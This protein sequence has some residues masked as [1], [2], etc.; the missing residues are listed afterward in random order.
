[1]KRWRRDEKTGDTVLEKFLENYKLTKEEGA[2]ALNTNPRGLDNIIKDINEADESFIEKFCHL[3]GYNYYDIFEIDSIKITEAFDKVNQFQKSF[4]AKKP[5]LDY[6]IFSIIHKPVISLLGDIFADKASCF[7]DTIPQI[8]F[9][10]NSH[11]PVY[12][13]SDKDA[14]GLNDERNPLVIT[15]KD[16]N[17]FEPVLAF[18]PE[19]IRSCTV[20]EYDNKT[21]YPANSVIILKSSFS[22]LKNCILLF[23][24][25]I[26][27]DDDS[28]KI[29]NDS[30]SI[31]VNYILYSD[32][33]V[34][35]DAITRLLTISETP[36]VQYLLDNL[37]CHKELLFV[38]TKKD[39]KTELANDDGY[40]NKQKD[41][42]KKEE[43]TEKAY[44][45]YDKAYSFKPI[46]SAQKDSIQ[47]KIFFY[48]YND[49]GKF[50]YKLNELSVSRAKSVINNIDSINDNCD[51]VQSCE[52]IPESK[53]LDS[54]LKEEV[55]KGLKVSFG[56]ASEV[57][58]IEKIL[59]K[60]KIKLGKIGLRSFI[61]FL[62]IYS[63][64]ILKSKLQLVLSD[65]LLTKILPECNL[66]LGNLI[67]PMI[68]ERKNFSKGTSETWAKI[69]SKKIKNTI[70][71]EYFKSFIFIIE[72]KIT[73]D[74]RYLYDRRGN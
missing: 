65:E 36:L 31:F 11:L 64:N 33:I 49:Q 2:K 59:K 48:D 32:I 38:A 41:I 45:A 73:F 55:Y 18:D 1:M 9:V 66:Y 44:N 23:L 26:V 3:S 35:F 27:Y 34:L 57:N 42:E 52:V 28:G 46:D 10:Q 47:E 61:I 5:G 29:A 39:L 51:I 19:Y 16:G 7:K 40:I 43:K 67:L 74:T 70:D 15:P 4:L 60:P 12:V 62:Q 17:Y 24:P 72:R 8:S 50:V 68:R 58:E 14:C 30:L 13:F 22:L 53:N 71:S 25:D 69:I 54:V 6:S 20:A 63:S 37:D 21:E 56:V